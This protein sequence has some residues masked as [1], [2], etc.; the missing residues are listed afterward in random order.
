M[1]TCN[2]ALKEDCISYQGLGEVFYKMGRFQAAIDVFKK[3][4]DLN[5]TGST[6][7][8]WMAI[9]DSEQLK[10]TLDV[11]PYQA[12]VDAFNQSL[13]LKEDWCTY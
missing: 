7:V 2:L 4:L 11:A 5:K 13:A 6:I 12:A 10:H 9:F 8:A 1:H 3:S